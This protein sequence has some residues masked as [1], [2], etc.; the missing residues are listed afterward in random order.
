MFLKSEKKKK[1]KEKIIPI[2]CKKF[3]D[4]GIK[5]AQ[6]EKNPEKTGRK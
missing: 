2:D 1:K 5:G 6:K 4:V 3:E